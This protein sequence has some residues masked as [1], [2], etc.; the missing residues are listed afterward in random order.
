MPTGTVADHKDCLGRWLR[1]ERTCALCRQDVTQAS[2]AGAIG[3]G[4]SADVAVPGT[5]GLEEATPDTATAAH[6][7]VARVEPMIVVFL[8]S[9]L[10]LLGAMIVT[11][12]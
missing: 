5:S 2:E 9:D 3:A 4:S 1:R 11:V 6:S 8:A 10:G 12:L 7:G